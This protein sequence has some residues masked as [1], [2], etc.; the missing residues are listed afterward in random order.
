MKDS[1]SDKKY[2]ERHRRQN[3]NHWELFV[4]DCIFFAFTHVAL[5]SAQKSSVCIPYQCKIRNAQSSSNCEA[6]ARAT[7]VSNRHNPQPCVESRQRITYRL[8]Q[9]EGNQLYGLWKKL[10]PAIMRQ[11]TI[12]TTSNLGELT[13]WQTRLSIFT[14]RWVMSMDFTFLLVGKTTQFIYKHGVRHVLLRRILLKFTPANFCFANEQS[15]VLDCPNYPSTVQTSTKNLGESIC[16][17]SLGYGYS[18]RGESG[19]TNRDQ[20]HLTLWV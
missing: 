11:A 13:T 2:V 12:A 16:T 19:Q 17:I 3:R 7:L 10:Y 8:I 9:E 1:R 6:Q 18:N 20:V 5:E 15:G 4:L 14:R